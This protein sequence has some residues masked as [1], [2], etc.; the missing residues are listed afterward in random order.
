MQGIEKASR[1]KKCSN[2]AVL[3]TGCS[4][5]IGRAIAVYLAE[6]GFKVFATVR[7]NKDA[8][9]LA[10]LQNPNLIPVYPL[11]LTN[12][13]HIKE[14]FEFVKKELNK[15]AIKGL[16]AI[17]NNAGGGSI[18]PI[19]LTDLDKFHIELQA[20]ILGPVALLQLFLPLIREVRGR[21]LWIATPALLPIP[22][23]ADI[24]ACD[25]AVN[26]IARTLQIELKPW[27]IPS[28]LIRCGGIKT[29]S[30]DKIYHDLDENIK[31]WR[32]EK[33]ELY[34][35]ALEKTRKEFEEF[36]KKRTDPLEAAKVVYRALIGKKPKRRYR[37][38][39]MSALAA[40]F[41]LFP[42][43]IIDYMM[44]RKNR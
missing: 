41:E 39:H 23:L 10:K 7:K 4:S 22:Y 40:F 17:I 12:P 26:C 9:S 11:D 30:P 3:V 38:G 16:Y 21:I 34:A 13:D 6:N 2:R 1:Y 14:V 19:E 42:Q 15:R 18:A 24:H 27:D 37:V 36:D 28:I 8:E 32:G 29:S 31:K 5:G 20:R 44:E 33:Y 35:K 43:T 25:F